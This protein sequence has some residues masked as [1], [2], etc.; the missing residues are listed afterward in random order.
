MVRYHDDDDDDSGSSRTLLITAGV[1]AGVLAGAV[2]AQRFGGWKGVRRLLKR[3]RSPLYAALGRVLPQG[4]L[5][6][7]LDVVGL[8]E[9]VRGLLDR[10]RRPSTRRRLR[11]HD[12]DLDEYE[13]DE[14]E[15]AVAG[16]DDE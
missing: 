5:A 10:T 2:V 7:L 6:T 1:L 3:R 4:T 8:E 9:M 14:I 16:L 12:P 15:R 11:R 13:V